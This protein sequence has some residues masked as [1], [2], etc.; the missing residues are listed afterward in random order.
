MPRC[1]GRGRDLAAQLARQPLVVEVAEPVGYRDRDGLGVDRQ[2]A[3][4]GMAVRGQRH[5][6]DD[7]GTQAGEG[8]HDELPPVRQLHDDPVTGR[9]AETE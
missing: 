5:H 9:E 4:L 1:P 3:Q 2:V 7:A 6:R 8:E